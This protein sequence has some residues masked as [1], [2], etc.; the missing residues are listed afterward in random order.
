[1]LRRTLFGSGLQCLERLDFSEMPNAPQ[2]DFFDD[3]I[4]RQSFARERGW[5]CQ[6]PFRQ[7]EKV[8]AEGMAHLV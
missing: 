6:H 5:L 3:W 8:L 2:Q 1:M 7:G 4:C